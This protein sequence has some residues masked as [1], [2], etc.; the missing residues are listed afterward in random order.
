MRAGAAAPRA[1]APVPASHR[2]ADLLQ[3]CYSLVELRYAAG[4]RSLDAL[5][6][7]VDKQ[8]PTFSAVQL[9]TVLT[10]LARMGFDPPVAFGARLCKHVDSLPPA[11]RPALVSALA[12]L[13]LQAA[14]P[15]EFA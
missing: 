2:P 1:D 11:G 15:Q 3:L 5:A 4:P 10:A 8:L 14:P 9:T 12:L 13:G 6:A 7:A